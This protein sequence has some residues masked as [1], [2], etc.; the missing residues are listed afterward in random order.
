M[1]NPTWEDE[2]YGVKLSFVLD[3]H[4]ARLAK[5]CKVPDGVC[6]IGR[7]EHS[8]RDY[9]VDRQAFTNILPASLT[10][11]VIFIDGDLSGLNPSFP[12]VC[13]FTALPLWGIFPRFIHG[14]VKTMAFFGTESLPRFARILSSDPWF[15]FET[16][17]TIFT[18]KTNSGDSV[19][20][21]GLF[22]GESVGWPFTLSV[23]IPNH[24][25]VSHDPVLHVPLP[26]A[27]LATKSSAFFSVFFHRKAFATHFTNLFNHCELLFGRAFHIMKRLS[28]GWGTAGMAVLCATH[29]PVQ[30]NFPGV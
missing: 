25:W 16:T 28:M 30:F 24:I 12:P 3:P 23:L 1:M 26:A 21:F 18:Y 10:S 19:Y 17:A 27:G 4:M 5:T 14:L 9:V 29:K 11:P 15:Y 20:G 7:R 22:R 8:E 13:C 6:F 2:K